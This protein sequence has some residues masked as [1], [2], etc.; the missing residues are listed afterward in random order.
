MMILLEL[1]RNDQAMPYFAT[2]RSIML[3]TE[4]TDTRAINKRGYGGQVEVK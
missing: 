4:T 1:A 3:A 2:Q